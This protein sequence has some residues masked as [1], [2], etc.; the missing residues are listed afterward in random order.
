MSG[1]VSV[2]IVTLMFAGS[3]LLHARLLP[4]DS[5]P[6]DPPSLFDGPRSPVIRRTGLSFCLE[7][8]WMHH[9]STPAAPIEQ[10]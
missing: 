1:G 6:P 4:D 2:Q 9:K 7:S 8:G 10:F 5:P 3:F